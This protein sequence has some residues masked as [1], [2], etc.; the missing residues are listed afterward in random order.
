[1]NETRFVVGPDQPGFGGPLFENPIHFNNS[2]H[3]LLEGDGH[4]EIH[5]ATGG[6]MGN[7]LVSA[8]DPLFFA[9][10]SNVDRLWV[11]WLNLGGGRRNPNEQDPYYKTW[12]DQPFTFFDENKKKVTVSTKDVLDTTKLDAP[13]V[14]DM[15][16]NVR[17]A[18]AGREGAGVRDEHVSTVATFNK[19]GRE[20]GA[21]PL[22]VSFR[23][24]EK[25]RAGLADV[26]K[27]SSGYAQLTLHGVKFSAER[28]SVIRVYLN[29]PK[30]TP[31]PG[32]KD[33]RYAGS[34][35]FFVHEH[36]H[37][38]GLTV[39]L[40]ITTAVRTLQKKEGM[41]SGDELTV[42]L[43]RTVPSGGKKFQSKL[44]FDKLTLEVRQPK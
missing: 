36:D 32:A 1:M 22:R 28:D 27:E 8:R 35:T 11:E 12:A 26:R 17:L 14:Y 13:Y 5:G 42:T 18:R 38:K 29:L 3:G 43:V 44:T 2:L 31:P 40:P 34:F 9:H 25:A 33:P 21:Q 16:P 23:L 7:P 41:W 10:H 24:G 15:F 6:W 37:E 20:L 30:D 19:P 39:S 4:D